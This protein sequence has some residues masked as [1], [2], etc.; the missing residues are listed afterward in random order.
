MGSGLGKGLASHALAMAVVALTAA[1]FL[2]VPYAYREEVPQRPER[3]ADA[4]PR[5]TA[6][7]DDAIR[8]IDAALDRGDVGA[9]RA[10]WHEAYRA[11]LRRRQWEEMAALGDAALRLT[12]SGQRIGEAQ[13]RQAYLAALFRARAASSLPGV[14]R[15]AGAFATL[16]DR[17]VVEEALRIAELTAGRTSEPGARDRIAA[18][19]A[20]L[21]GSPRADE[22]Q[23]P[24]AAAR[25]DPG[26]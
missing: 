8:A 15:A 12:A 23:R 26:P 19:R 13:A 21:D 3:T 11:G 18:F 10:E 16:G 9:A 7:P 22:P 17:D 1:L 14:L 2:A 24:S 4:R 5:S 20:R 25:W 6:S